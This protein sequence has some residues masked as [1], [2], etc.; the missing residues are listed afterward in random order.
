MKKNFLFKIAMIVGLILIF[1]VLITACEDNTVPKTPNTV[2]DTFYTKGFTKADL[3]VQNATDEL[4]YGLF[5][6]LKPVS[7]QRDSSASSS[8]LSAE[9]PIV[10]GTVQYVFVLKVNYSETQINDNSVLCEIYDKE[11]ENLVLGIYHVN[12]DTEPMLYL[13]IGNTKLKVP[14][15]IDTMNILAPVTILDSTISLTDI[16]K[17]KSDTTIKYEYKKE[18]STY[19]KHFLV[20]IDLAETLKSLISNMKLPGSQLTS[21][22][23]DLNFFL[24]NM[25]GVTNSD[26]SSTGLPPMYVTVECTTIEGMQNTF[27][28]GRLSDMKVKLEVSSS[29]THA[30]TVFGGIPY[31]GS[32]Q[33]VD[34]KS[35]NQLINNLFANADLG[36]FRRYDENPLR[37]TLN[38][39]YLAE[40]TTRKYDFIAEIDYNSEDVNKTKAAIYIYDNIKNSNRLSIYLEDGVLWFNHLGNDN[41]VVNLK[42]HFDLTKVIEDLLELSPNQPDASL[43]NRSV[44]YILGAISA[45]DQNKLRYTYS[46]ENLTTLL[47]IAHSDI[48]KI[49]NEATTGMDDTSKNFY[50]LYNEGAG[51][52][53]EELVS[54]KV[55]IQLSA[56]DTFITSIE[57]VNLP[58][59]EE[60]G[61]L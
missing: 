2:V 6:T 11:K 61:Q 34:F 50:D 33:V 47:G 23:S 56:S 27:K 51:K 24:T 26:I 20:N 44:V 55:A 13:R 37:I 10:L 45:S 40:S 25:L 49:I 31:E 57:E 22:S 12:S 3:T 36:S 58:E 9:A 35:S 39:Y 54:S 15:S 19:T 48:A 52:S 29:P 14:C 53:F 8:S 21:Y 17:L 59:E 1:G 41:T 28:S 42:C 16:I 5:N 43:F 38:F 18:N 7:Q 32:F 60:R 4:L 30:N 46:I